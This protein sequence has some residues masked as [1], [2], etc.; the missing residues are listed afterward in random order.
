MRFI[1]LLGLALVH[2]LPVLA[3]V[4]RGQENCTCGFYD[5]QTKELFTDSIIVYFNET[6][7][8]PADFVAE[9]FQQKYGKDWV[10]YELV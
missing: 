3:D 8:I 1:P 2:V 5:G 9:E 4:S 10:C 7:G 6:T